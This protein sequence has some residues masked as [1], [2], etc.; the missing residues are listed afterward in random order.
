MVSECIIVY[1]QVP[2]LT[3]CLVIHSDGW[4]MAHRVFLLMQPSFPGKLHTGSKRA[5][6]SKNLP[7]DYVEK[8]T[9]G[10]PTSHS[11]K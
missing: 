1:S 8:K 4:E 10:K 2:P 9:G 3:N 5:K 6:S 7:S 11:K